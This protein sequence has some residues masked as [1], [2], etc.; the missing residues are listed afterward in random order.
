MLYAEKEILQCYTFIDRHEYLSSS[1]IVL[2]FEHKWKK[3]I[4]QIEEYLLVGEEKKA[5]V[6]LD[7]YST[8]ELRKEKIND[9]KQYMYSQEIDEET[10]DIN[11]KHLF[12]TFTSKMRRS[13]P[14]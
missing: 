7:K 11:T 4:L 12:S 14:I 9:L 2:S 10:I 13:T 8:L 3:I 5:D 1:K 6:L